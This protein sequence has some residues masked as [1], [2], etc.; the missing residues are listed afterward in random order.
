MGN[1]NKI[2]PA[3]GSMAVI[4]ES[5][6][7]TVPVRGVTTEQLQMLS[8]VS[9]TDGVLLT[10]AGAFTTAATSLFVEWSR[11]SADTAVIFMV[12]AVTFS[13]LA[14]GCGIGMFASWRKRKSILDRIEKQNQ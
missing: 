5:K 10:G 6:E 12:L 11:A 2:P 1:E 14:V 4:V 13:L 9:T 8:M 3:A 7:F